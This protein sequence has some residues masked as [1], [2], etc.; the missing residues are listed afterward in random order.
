MIDVCV[1]Y[2]RHAYWREFRT[3]SSV[4]LFDYTKLFSFDYLHKYVCGNYG[5]HSK[6]HFDMNLC[7]L[8][9]K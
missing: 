2:A 3:M 6:S 5:A 1:N 9:S 4:K 8:E 7:R